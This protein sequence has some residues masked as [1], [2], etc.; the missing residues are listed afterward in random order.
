M[1]A[2]FF[3][4]FWR[5]TRDPFFIAFAIGF[6][7]LAVQRVLLVREFGLIEN[8]AAAYGVRLLAFLVIVYAVVIKNRERA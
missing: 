5:Q 8:R 6:A 2:A 7:V 3:L 4:R 1:A